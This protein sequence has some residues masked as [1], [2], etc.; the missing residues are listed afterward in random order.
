LTE[1]RLSTLS[2]K[3]ELAKLAFW[4][5]E[6]ALQRPLTRSLLADGA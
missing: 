3:D 6:E 1:G 5:I 4:P 2:V